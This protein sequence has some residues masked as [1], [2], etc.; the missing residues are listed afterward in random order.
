MFLVKQ[1]VPQAKGRL[2]LPPHLTS[3][4]VTLVTLPKEMQ[5]AMDYDTVQLINKRHAE[6]FGII[7]H[8]LDTNH[9]VA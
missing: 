1:V 5:Y 7:P 2:F 3:L 8:P 6:F 9:N 4:T